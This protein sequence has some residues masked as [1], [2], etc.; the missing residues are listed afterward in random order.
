MPSR[1][2][3]WENLAA[4]ALLLDLADR[5]VTVTVR[6]GR[7]DVR[8]AS[9]VTPEEVTL[10]RSY[11]RDLLIL[12]LACTDAVLDRLLDMRAGRLLEASPVTAP[13][14]CH[15]CGTAL[16]SDREHGRCGW[17]ALA[18]RLYASAPLDPDL[19]HLF[20]ADV[21]GPVSIPVTLDGAALPFDVAIPA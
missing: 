19:L 5:G 10:L 20:P 4:R 17:C 7:L 2:D 15:C 18:S 8:P 6:A 21:R 3:A 11:K 12:V 16:P 13:G 9:L 14:L 1:S